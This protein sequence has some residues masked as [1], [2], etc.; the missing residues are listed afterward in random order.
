[1]GNRPP[2]LKQE[3]TNEENKNAEDHKP[4]IL[5]DFLKGEGK[6]PREFLQFIL[7]RRKLILIEEERIE[8]GTRQ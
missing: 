5:V 8:F 4:V 6:V 3:I 2:P 7:A 1:M